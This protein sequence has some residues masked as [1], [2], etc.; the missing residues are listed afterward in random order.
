MT[1]PPV[2]VVH[3]PAH[4][5]AALT[6]AAG[7]PLILL[8]PAGAAG[9]HGVV[10]WLRLLETIREE[11]PA[12]PFTGA[13]D[14][15]DGPGWAMAALRMGAERIV[16]AGHGPAWEAVKLAAEQI[17]AW[18]EGRWGSDALDL[19]GVPDP[20]SACRDFLKNR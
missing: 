1:A 19:L 6:A 12:A 2:I 5:R 7:R 9:L 14:C 8:S 3:G 15:A 11:F 10:W 13:L 16:L 17:G 4:A 18:G 20:G